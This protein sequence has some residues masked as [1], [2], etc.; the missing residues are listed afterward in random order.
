MISFQFAILFS[1]QPQC[2]IIY[3]LFND[4]TAVQ[5]GDKLA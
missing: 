2:K 4:E 3:T 5:E 1:S